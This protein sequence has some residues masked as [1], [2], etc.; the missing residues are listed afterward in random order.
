G[1]GHSDNWMPQHFT[2]ITPQ[3][4]DALRGFLDATG[5]TCIWGLNL[6]TGTPERGAE[7]AAYVFKALGPKLKFFEIANEPDL[8]LMPLRRIRPATWGF[9]D[10]SNEWAAI[11][12]AVSR[13]VPDARFGGDASAGWAV[14]FADAAP[15]RFGS[16]IVA[17][18]SHHYAEG[19]PE[20]PESTIAKL[21]RR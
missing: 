4:V 20:S 2:P 13:R 5:W 1:V 11:A 8:F 17:V 15:A 3:A 21:L 7:E 6:G 9:A 16:S 10:Y 19:P 12:D 14:Q 18:A